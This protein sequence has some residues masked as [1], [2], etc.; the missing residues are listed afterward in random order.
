MKKPW[1]FRIIA[2]YV[3]LQLPA[4]IILIVLLLLAKRWV[5]L[6]TWFIWGLTGLWIAKDVALFPLTW[7]AYDPDRAKTES[8][9]VGTQ[10]IAE[11]RLNP[12]G[13]IRVG[14]ELWMAEVAGGDKPIERGQRVRVHGIRGL[15]LLVSYGDHEARR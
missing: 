5:D 3:L 11:E 4:L 6:P 14:G 8:P 7:H 12:S 9:M 1:S 15:T 13:Y 2:R 10:G